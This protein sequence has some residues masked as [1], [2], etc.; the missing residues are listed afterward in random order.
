MSPSDR[1]AYMVG[2]VLIYWS[3]IRITNKMSSNI[4]EIQDLVKCYSFAA[5]KHSEQRRKDPEKT[6]YIN[7]P[8]GEKIL[9]FY[10]YVIF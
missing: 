1:L 3:I 6:P 7:H 5:V 10:F 8:I 2:A 9:K 4:Q